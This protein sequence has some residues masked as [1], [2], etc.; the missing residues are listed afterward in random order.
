MF[1]RV[2]KAFQY[3]DF[4]NLWLGAC[5]SSIGTW[6]QIVAQN[7]LVLELTNS[8][9]M[10]G[11]DSFLGQIPIFLLSLIGGVVADRFDR[12]HLLIGSQVLQMTCAFSLAGLYGFGFLKV[13]HILCLSFTIGIAQAFGGPA[14]QALVPSLV[15][16]EDVPNAIAMNSIQFNLARIIGPILGGLARNNLGVTWCFLLNGM[17]F[18]AV[19]ISLFSIPMRVLPAKTGESVLQSMKQGFAFIRTKEAMASLIVLAFSMTLLAYPLIVMLPVMVKDVLHGDSR[20]FDRMMVIS[21][22][23]S[24]AGALLVAAAGH[25]KRK[26]LFALILITILGVLMTCFG[27]SSNIWVSGFFIFLFGAVMVSCFS[28]I[29]SLVQL[30]TPD[31]MRGRVMSVYNV[32]FRGGMPF[33]SLAAGQTAETFSAPI[34]VVANG[35]L[36]TILGA[37]FLFGHRKIAKL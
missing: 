35:G 8:P 27:L 19:I 3:R 9:R 12:R 13:W 14:Y 37:W 7:W 1:Q 22:A 34:A 15:A 28:M 11:L 26:G 32:A 31:D 18:V 24:V 21:G 29:A 20:V 4:R 10:L 2:F 30:I 36:L 25:V 16:K 5:T 6:M 17:S 33:G 23:G